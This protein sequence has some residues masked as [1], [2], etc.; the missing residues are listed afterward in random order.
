MNHLNPIFLFCILLI[1]SGCCITKPDCSPEG[2]NFTFGPELS[3]RSSKYTGS[4]AR[5]DD[6]KRLG[7]MGLGVFGH[8][9]FCEDY[10]D[11]GFYSGLFYNQ[12]GVKY[13]DDGVDNKDRLHYLSIP[14]TFTYNVYNG[15]TV[16]AGPD[17]SFLLSAKE[18][19]TYMGNKEKNNFSDD[20]HNV[21]LGYNIAVSYMHE[22]I[23]LGGFF[24]WNG[25]FNKVPSSNYDTKLYN[26]GFSIGARYRLNHLVGKK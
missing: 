6:T 12:H 1:I 4:N 9:I 11:M 19:Y 2:G 22:P 8:W 13:S 3:Y 21:Q 24:R 17:L 16:E 14:F 26:G 18:I 25:G 5:S 10:P 7:S 15:V 23:G 20:V